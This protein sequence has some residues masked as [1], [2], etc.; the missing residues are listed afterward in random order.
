MMTVLWQ[1]G[2]RMLE[3]MRESKLEWPRFT[4]AQMTDLIAY[5][6]TQN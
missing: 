2:P 1:H 4:A 5:L 3:R 6:N